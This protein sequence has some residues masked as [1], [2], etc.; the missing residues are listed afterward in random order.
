M[1]HEGCQ[2]LA[3]D[4]AIT[5]EKQNIQHAAMNFMDRMDEYLVWCTD[6]STKRQLERERHV[7]QNFFIQTYM[8]LDHM[9]AIVYPREL[10]PP[11]DPRERD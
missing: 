11:Q 7:L 2:R 6:A 5:R 8:S 10:L 1:D 3:L 4:L 9:K